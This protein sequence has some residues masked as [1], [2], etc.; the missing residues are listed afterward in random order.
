[1][2]P[3]RFAHVAP[4]LS[5]AHV[6]VLTQS[7]PCLSMSAKRRKHSLIYE[8][9][10]EYLKGQLLDG[11][12]RPGDQLPTVAELSDQLD[13]GQ[14]SVREAYRILENRGVLEVTQGRGTFV[15]TAIL[16]DADLLSR[17]KLNEH[18]SRIHVLEARKILEPS[19]AALAAERATLAEADAILKAAKESEGREP[20]FE[21]WT[22]INI[23]F[24]DLV[25]SAAHNP[26][27][28]HMLTAVHDLIRDSWP[29]ADQ[30]PSTPEKATHFHKLIALAIKDGDANSAHTLMYQH[31]ETFTR[32]LRRYVEVREGPSD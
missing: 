10:L 26:V 29:R 18:P 28:A 24:H 13:V 14:A 2:A 15:S 16:D 9:V 32:D 19:I 12:F 6:H 27:L 5:V 21:E 20:D 23:R 1:M 30:I 3:F 17:F 8:S 11:R 4:Q 31:I 22:E 7:N 25:V